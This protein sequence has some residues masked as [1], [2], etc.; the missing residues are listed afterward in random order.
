MSEALYEKEIKCPICNNKFKTMKVRKNACIVDK[1]DSD[2]CTHY[3]NHNPIFYEIFVC[4][5]CGYSAS[6]SSFE[7]L[8]K[9]EVQR[10]KEVFSGFR[11][12]RS[13]C[14][15]RNISDAID[16]FKLALY[17]S[18]SKEA[19]DSIIAGTCLK[20]A[21]LYRY[22]GDAKERTFIEYALENYVKAYNVEDFPI[23]SFDEITMQYIMG[24]LSR[25]LGKYDD[26][27]LWLSKA[28]S[29]P[30]RSKNPRIEKMARE[31]WAL[32]KEEYKKVKKT[33]TL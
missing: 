26:A 7:D 18:K 9:N 24:E 4:P 30:E 27:I 5:F 10:L 15:E 2:F 19:K 16:S 31:Q 17:T 28:V 32:A 6:E 23:G 20:I 21:W 33:E 12:S 22:L 29:N 13:F 8:T 25:R 14:D 11:V 1:K 3:K